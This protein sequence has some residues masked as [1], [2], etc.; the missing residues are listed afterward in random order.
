MLHPFGRVLLSVPKTL[1]YHCHKVEGCWGQNQE[2]SCPLH[3][4]MA[5]KGGDKEVYSF[6]QHI[7][8]KA[9]HYQTLCWEDGD[10]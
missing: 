6:L 1:G 7:L 8:W 4:L 10:K 5:R 2:L 3:M 9:R